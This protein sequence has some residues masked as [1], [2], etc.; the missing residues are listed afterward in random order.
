MEKYLLQQHNNKKYN[1]ELTL[2]DWPI[3]LTPKEEQ[4]DF[5]DIIIVLFSFPENLLNSY[6]QA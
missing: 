2:T 3:D 4:K 5:Y 6:W 1:Q